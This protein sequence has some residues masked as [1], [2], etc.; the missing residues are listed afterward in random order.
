VNDKGGRVIG[1]L[2]T[3]AAH[4]VIVHGASRLIGADYP[5]A[6]ARRIREKLEEPVLPLFAQ[7]CGGN[8]NGHP[9]RGGHAM[10]EEAGNRLG[11]AVLRALG[12]SAPLETPAFRVVSKTV[13][14]PCRELPTAEACATAIDKMKKEIAEC[15]PEDWMPRDRLKRLEAL[16]TM[17]ERGQPP[18]V[19]FEAAAVMSGTGWC[20]LAMT[21]EVFCDYALWM[22]EVSPFERKMVCAY[23][24]GCETYV[25]TDEDLE[26]GGYEAV[27]FPTQGAA[28]A[29]PSRLALR[30]G[31][32]GQVKETLR[33]LWA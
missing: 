28:L 19:R 1:V 20:L 32:E 31:V 16:H 26:L 2:F 27:S 8:I 11:E 14:L 13:F 33:G 7:G 12:D 23:T 29:Y 18:Q 30:P 6:A 15:A 9:L 25:P 10:A 22:E 3:H 21:H 17:I 4:P 24:N 5:A